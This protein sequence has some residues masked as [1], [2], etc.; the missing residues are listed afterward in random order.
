VKGE[1]V[2]APDGTAI[3]LADVG[4]TEL[5]DNHAVRIW[6]V[7]LD[8][9]G[10]HPWHQHHNPYV[11]LS[12]RGSE[13]RMDWLDG[14]PPR[15]I[16]EYRGGAVYRPVS[17]VHRL[18]NLKDQRY[19]NRLVELKDL[20]ELRPQPLDVGP[21]ARS[22]EGHSLGSDLPDGRRPV[23]A[24]PHVSVWTV[25][26]APGEKTTLA[27]AELPHVLALIDAPEP[28]EEPS[29][30]TSFRE[31]GP[32]TLTNCTAKSQAWFVVQLTYLH[33][34]DAVADGDGI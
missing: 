33:D 15:F 28:P 19:Q 9:R 12:L 31:G 20:G 30:G 21:G 24:H 32:V 14:S 3:A 8:G 4:V 27:L 5:L 26:V 13:G 23:I 29:G 17:P 34:L 18:T 22:V 10:Q 16:T 25:D 2:H 6:D 7:S 1:I 11:V